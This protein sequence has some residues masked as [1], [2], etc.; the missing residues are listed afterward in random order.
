MFFEGAAVLAG[1]IVL[2]GSLAMWRM[3]SGPLDLG[4]A[5]D[6][7]QQA[8]N[9]PVSGYSVK[10]GSVVLTWPE[11]SSPMMLEL[12]DV[13]LV[14]KD[15][16]V[17]T[18]GKADVGISGPSLLTGHID[19]TSIV[20]SEPALRLI[21][22]DKNE[23][24]L[25]LEDEK[26]SSADLEQEK[27]PLGDILAS[28]AQPVGSIDSRS[29][30]NRLQSLEIRDARMIMEDH[31]MGVS[32]YLRHLDILFARNE[33]GLVMTAGIQLPG[34][35]DQAASIQGE[36]LYERSGGDIKLSLHFQDFD[37]RVLSRKIEK[38]SWLGQQELYIN[39]DMQ[40]TL[41]KEMRVKDGSISLYA[42]GGVLNM[43]ETYSHPLPFESLALEVAYDSAKNILNI[44]RLGL[45]IHG[46]SVGLSSAISIS[47]NEVKAPVKILVPELP[48]ETIK[49]LWPDALHG[50]SIEVWMTHNLSQGK[51][52][53]LTVVFDAAA[54]KQENNLW[55]MDVSA[56]KADFGI[57]NMTVDYRAPLTP[58]TKTHGH[59]RFLAD[60]LDIA[61]DGADVGD[62]K[63]TK[64]RVTIDRIS[65]DVPG[66]AK[67]DVELKAALPSVFDY[68][69][70]EPIK[71]T[72]ERLGFKAAEVKGAA[73]L[74]VNV[75]FPTI[76]H[77]LAEQVKVKVN[78][79]LHDMVLPGVVRD[80]MSLTGG[81]FNLTVDGGAVVLSGKG[82]L[83]DRDIDMTWQQYLESAGKPF[84]SQVRASLVADR[85]LREKL[86]IH[87]DDWV[88][89]ALPA[90]VVYTEYQDDRAE[91]VVDA[92]VG[93]AKL[94]VKPFSHEK[95]PGGAGTAHC[96]VA[97]KGGV[98][99][100]VSDLSV[101]APDIK[102][103]GARLIF[104]R[105]GAENVLRR[106]T[107]PSLVLGKTQAAIDWESDAKSGILKINVKGAALDARPFLGRRK[108]KKEPSAE[109]PPMAI[110]IDVQK[111]LT[112]G[113]EQV[114]KSR[115]A[116]NLDRDGLLT[117]MDMDVLAGKGPFIIRVKPDPSG[118]MS[119]R[120]QADDAGAALR[121]FD[122]Y[123][124]IRG[125]RLSVTGLSKDAANRRTI[126]GEAR[127][128]DFYVIKAPALAQLVSA[129]SPTG[130]PQL[131]S[132]E[133]IYFSQLQSK[134]VWRMRPPGDIFEIED[135]RTS[136]SS[137][138]LTFEG[139]IN[140]EK[141][142]LLIE[143]D[144][145]PVSEVNDLISNIPLVGDVLMGGTEGA[146]FAATYSIEGSVDKPEVSVN[147]L[148]V[149]APGILRK[150][151][152]EG[153]E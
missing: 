130:L 63:V 108:D 23:I 70:R 29:P 36:A 133:G 4:F 152:F 123:R 76:K 81:P 132:G 44:E 61:I 82:K 118:R 137:L 150:I 104:E 125:G 58:A 10:L 85:E 24:R 32:W 42:Q 77:L 48:Q 16:T 59:G 49:A 46:V 111:M 116:L 135:G 107:I 37:Q 86:N 1:L 105:K 13:S 60:T 100:E 74:V 149:L 93:P 64:G 39:G 121:A 97:L 143:G 5:R 20:L 110:T 18:V 92:D 73:D 75:S 112:H 52:K 109:G 90:R 62:M 79:T 120:M 87:L 147:P 67:I 89:G 26:P 12:G 129:I 142:A 95:Q 51:I 83:E 151:F 53:D 71:M 128:S 33:R 78:G 127:L 119:L 66:T 45:D 102:M 21:R 54:R 17:L 27:N 84:S 113:E 7:I 131:L 96:K 88:E 57:E 72:G 69:A 139:A 22:T 115:V 146:I 136:G 98:L 28:L 50:K 124:N 126:A 41:D 31:I 103:N 43:P 3:S 19:L 101:Q 56:V 40:A 34:G 144:V 106:G 141:N 153:G 148:A 65:R 140:K 6:Y 91:A 47:D 15:Q 2:A 134:F 30:L 138:G 114:Q 122:V 8:L 11:F 117:Q 68:I 38:V 99:Q 80:Q 35:R 14:K 94:M 145:V 9:D 25:S 55:D